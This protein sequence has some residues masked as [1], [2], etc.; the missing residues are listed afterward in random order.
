M[1]QEKLLLAS[2]SPRRREL[3][4]IMGIPFDVCTVSIE[5]DHSG[6]AKETVMRLARE[7]AVAAQKLFPER[8]ILGADTLVVCNGKTLG[9]PKDEADAIH[10]LQMLSGNVN[11]VYTGICLLDGKAGY[12]NTD[13]DKTDVYFL[14]VDDSSIRK[15]VSSG[16]PMDKAGAY[17]V[18]GMGGMFVYRIEGSPSNVIGLPMHLVRQMLIESG[19]KL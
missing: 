4:D 18:Q 15:Y 5:E 3:L 2:A 7:K 9:K 17:G 1:K 13:F 16:E 6:C 8:I 12:I 10:M 19:W 14:P 11:S